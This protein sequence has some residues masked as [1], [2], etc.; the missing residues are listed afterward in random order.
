MGKYFG[1]D[2]IR[3]KADEFSTEFIQSVAKG[4]AINDNIKVLI[5]GDTRESS[6]WILRDFECSFET[7]G[8]EYGNVG[9]LPT[10]AINEVFYEMGFDYA[11]DI[12]ASHNPATDNGIKIFERG[13]NSGIKLSLEMQEKIEKAID[14]GANYE[15]VSTEIREDLHEDALGRY[16]DSLEQYLEVVDFGGLRIGLD[17]ANG[18]TSVVG[19]SLFEKFGAE[20]ILINDNDEYGD[21]INHNCGSTHPES[22]QELVVQEG[23]DFGAAFDGDG[24]RCILVDR[25]GKIVDGDQMMTILI[26]YLGL[27]SAVTTVMANQGLLEWAK[28]NNVEIV[29]TKVGDQYVSAEM[30]EKDI[31][32]GGEQSGHIILPGK[33]MGDGMLTALMIA[34]I[35]SETGRD[36]TVLASEM[37]RFPQVLLNM[38]ANEVEKALLSSDDKIKELISKYDKIL[39]KMGGRMLVR[40]SGTENL[41]R[42]TMWGRDEKQITDLAEKLISELK[43]VMESKK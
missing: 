13:E 28:V 2:G 36:L 30:R 19:G 31:K 21:E 11:I 35:I 4:L 26:E 32:L 39:A 34:K 17:C 25:D 43:K 40:P 10:P 20:V 27:D 37:Q 16:L 41:V 6:E 38:P 7:L 18:A 15:L 12:T 8:I 14:E 42:V 3:R 22:L 5:G 9:I 24:D 1:T 23:L 29:T 33:A